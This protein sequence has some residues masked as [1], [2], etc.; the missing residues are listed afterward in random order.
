VK[1]G[2]RASK[3]VSGEEFAE[4]AY[5]FLRI[6]VALILV[7]M[8]YWW[9]TEPSNSVEPYQASLA[10]IWSIISN[11]IWEGSI[12]QTMHTTDAFTQINLHHPNFN[13]GIVP[14]YVSDE[15][16]GLHEV[17]F[18]GTLMLL[19]PGV[20]LRTRWRSVAA[21][22]LVVQV[23]NMIR[24][25]MLYPLAVSGCEQLPGAYGCEAPMT[26]FHNFILSSGFLAILVMIWLAWFVG[27]KIN[28]KVGDT[29]AKLDELKQF[30][31][32]RLRESLPTWSR[33]LIGMGL[34]LALAGTQMYVLDDTNQAHKVM[35]QDCTF[36][37]Q[38]WETS[39]GDSCWWEKARWEE[40]EGRAT[41]AWLFGGLFVL[42]G[43]LTTTPAPAADEEE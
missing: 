27:L 9:A 28:G 41:R 32:L 40:A 23:L 31:H 3:D 10:S 34:L 19:T 30:Q 1:R 43:V 25:V 5:G 13:G 36:G 6:P 12:T 24:L 16:A 22:T 37:E 8:I 17:I 20:S 29:R 15:C 14:V 18:L 33:V 11:M 38:G 42:A 4:M 39:D 26:E 21:M 35:A 7:E 2:G